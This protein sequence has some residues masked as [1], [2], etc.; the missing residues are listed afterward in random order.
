M[1]C[2]RR[3]SNGVGN[4]DGVNVFNCQSFF[5]GTNNCS[6][7]DVETTSVQNLNR[8]FGCFFY[9]SVINVDVVDVADTEPQMNICDVKVFQLNLR[10]EIKR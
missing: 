3:D 1:E 6:V 10:S 2:V 7:S 4:F 8:V 9:D 5:C